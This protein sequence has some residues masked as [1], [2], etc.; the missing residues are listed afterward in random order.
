MYGIIKNVIN[1]GDYELIEMLY[2]INKMYMESAITEEEKTGLDSLARQNAN[3]EKSY[4]PL[5]EQ[6]DN[7]YK[8]LELIKADIKEI[9]G[10]EPEEPTEEYPEFVQP[11]GA[12]DAYNEGD[13]I[14]YKNKK[15]VCK[16][17]GCVWSPEIYPQGW[18]EV[19]ESEV[20][21]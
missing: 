5:Q 15:Y 12:H 16:M 13:K 18:E 3:A 2:K 17:N 8:E 7:I 14:T 4:A 6:I 19:A 1:S 21:E 11:S 10:E 20:Q 9:K